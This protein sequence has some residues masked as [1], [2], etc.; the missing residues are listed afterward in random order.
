MKFAVLVWVVL[1][2][3]AACG[4]TWGN[5]YEGDPTENA[6]AAFISVH[7]ELS[8]Y[9]AQRARDL[10]IDWV[11]VADV[12]AQCDNERAVGCL[13]RYD[14]VRADAMIAEGQGAD[15]VAHETL[16]VIFHCAQP[17]NYDGNHNHKDAAWG[18]LE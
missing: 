14:A 18:V 2:C 7:G 16:H 9:C 6:I 12:R 17:F 4:P 11:P 3:A 10:E 15:V 5:E 13:Y 8:E 1:M